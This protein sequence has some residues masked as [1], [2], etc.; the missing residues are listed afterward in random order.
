MITIKHA[1]FTYLCR[2]DQNT[3]LMGEVMRKVARIQN[4]AGISKMYNFWGVVSPRGISYIFINFFF[5][6]PYWRSGWINAQMDFGSYV[7][8]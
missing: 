2:H 8:G 1:K 5:N 7:Y 6:A 4:H 3:A